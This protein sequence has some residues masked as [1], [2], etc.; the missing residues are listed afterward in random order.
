MLFASRDIELIKNSLGAAEIKTRLESNRAQSL[1]KMQDAQKLS[2]FSSECGLL[3]AAMKKGETAYSML[4]LELMIAT[5]RM[6]AVVYHGRGENAAS[7]S[8]RMA[9]QALFKELDELATRMAK[10]LG[11]IKPLAN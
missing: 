4:N 2:Q 9:S 10:E 1:L 7:I 8:E 3:L 6:A 11:A 5:V